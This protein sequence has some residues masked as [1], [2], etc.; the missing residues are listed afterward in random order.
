MLK[1]IGTR[2]IARRLES[3]GG[4]R[5]GGGWAVDRG[6]SCVSLLLAGAVGNDE[7]ANPRA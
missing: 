4:V 6:R 1:Y 3:A 2:I 5:G 7:K